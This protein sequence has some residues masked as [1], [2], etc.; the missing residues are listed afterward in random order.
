MSKKVYWD[1]IRKSIRS[2]SQLHE[3]PYVIGYTRDCHVS[4]EEKKKNWIEHQFFFRLS[5]M[6]HAGVEVGGM[7]KNSNTSGGSRENRSGSLGRCCLHERVDFAEDVAAGFG[8]HS[9]CDS[10]V[11]REVPAHA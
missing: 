5:K 8:A 10:H 11:V 4:V 6:R 3:A 9:V 2:C 1:Q 7:S